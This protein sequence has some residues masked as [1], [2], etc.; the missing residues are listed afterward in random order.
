MVVRELIEMRHLR[1]EHVPI[2]RH[3]FTHGGVTS[4]SVAGAF[5]QFH[6][7]VSVPTN[8][9]AHVDIAARL[10]KPLLE[11]RI[12]EREKKAGRNLFS[13]IYSP[14]VRGIKS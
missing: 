4:D 14:T 3:M 1:P 10:M 9:Q 6:D 7:H 5:G 2:L 8:Q 12:V 11:L 13:L